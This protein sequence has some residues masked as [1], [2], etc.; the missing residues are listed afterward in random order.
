MAVPFQGPAISESFTLYLGYFTRYLS[1]MVLKLTVFYYA[2]FL[3]Y[4]IRYSFIEEG[5]K[6]DMAFMA[7]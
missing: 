4:R 3:A 7:K 6:G 1:W 2:L 5:G